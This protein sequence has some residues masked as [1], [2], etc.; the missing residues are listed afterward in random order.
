MNTV[1]NTETVKTLGR[2]LLPLAIAALLAL[3]VFA[4]TVFAC[5]NPGGGC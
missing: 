5:N 4:Q 1:M 3:T 2:R